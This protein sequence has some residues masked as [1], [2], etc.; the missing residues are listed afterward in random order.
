MAT[1]VG[2]G[3]QYNAITKA[4]IGDQNIYNPVKKIFVGSNGVYNLAY[5][6]TTPPIL[7]NKLESATSTIG[8][9]FT[10]YGTGISYPACK[11]NNGV[12]IAAGNEGTLYLLN[13]SNYI[14]KDKWTIEFWFKYSGKY[15][16]GGASSSGS[17]PSIITSGPWLGVG[18]SYPYLYFGH[19]TDGVKTQ[20]NF[21]PN[22]TVN[23]DIRNIS[24][25]IAQNDIVFWSFV[26]DNTLSSPNRLKLYYYNYTTN[27]SGIYTENNST[28]TFNNVWATTNARLVLGRVQG[29]FSTYGMYGIYDNIKIYD[30]AKTDFS[31]RNTE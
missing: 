13:S 23:Y 30:Y 16:V 15:V 31:D 12:T 4:F 26:Y 1:K 28:G 29:S 9:N 7:W 19:R 2:S 10:E 22:A 27:A 25:N 6:S 24:I 11:F 5:T 8:A 20:L 17:N 3:N 18:D 14:S 21:L